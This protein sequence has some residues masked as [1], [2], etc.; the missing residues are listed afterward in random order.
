MTEIKF[1]GLQD[2]STIENLNRLDSPF[3]KYVGFV[4]APSKRQV[5]LQQLKELTAYL[6]PNLKP[7][8]V[9]VNPT[10]EALEGALNS[11]VQ[12]LQFHGN[13]STESI[14][15]HLNQLFGKE[16]PSHIQIWKAIPVSSMGLN[17]SELSEDV[18]E[19]LSEGL[20]EETSSIYDKYLLDKWAPSSYGGTGKVFDW[21]LLKTISLPRE[22]VIVAGGIHSGNVGKLL[23]H[24]TPGG[25]DVSSGIETA[26][27]KDLQKI[28]AFLSAIEETSGIQSQTML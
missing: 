11:G 15:Q 19:D 25:I 4:L 13:E 3:L 20:F 28:L 24:Y 8:G 7:V 9:F 1:C 22:K 12:I 17:L 27:K 2:I 5:T 21:D 26:G 23:E 6:S 18:L 14:K 16:K 10:I